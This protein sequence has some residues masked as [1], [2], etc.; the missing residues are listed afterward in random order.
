MGAKSMSD[1]LPIIHKYYNFNPHS[2]QYVQTV[3]NAPGSEFL[4]GL[5]AALWR[6]LDLL[7]SPEL[8]PSASPSFFPICIIPTETT[9]HTLFIHMT[10]VSSK[11][12]GN[13]V[14]SIAVSGAAAT[15]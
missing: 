15:S 12:N 4:G 6:V 7:E 13:S 2:F 1:V 3:K 11:E 10:S 14:L 9:K 5:T 8:V